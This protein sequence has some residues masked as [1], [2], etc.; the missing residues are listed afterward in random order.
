[1]FYK[2][3]VDLERD[4]VRKLKD[5]V[6]KDLKDY[7]ICISNFETYISINGGM[8]LLPMSYFSGQIDLIRELAII[9]ADDFIGAIDGKLKSSECKLKNEEFNYKSNYF[10]ILG[11]I[12]VL[13][14]IKGFSIK[15]EH[16]KEIYQ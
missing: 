9:D 3:V 8:Y 7:I 10:Y 12:D 4:E 14:K 15:N 5:F 11:K 13:N 6:I 2:K 1:V 16:T